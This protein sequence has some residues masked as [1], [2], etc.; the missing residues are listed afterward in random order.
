VNG[1]VLDPA[2]QVVLCRNR[3]D[4]AGEDDERMAVTTG[5][6]REQHVVAREQRFERQLVADVGHGLRLRAAHRRDAHKRECA[7]GQAVAVFLLGH[8]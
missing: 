1:P 8:G 2:R 7:L 6:R 5:C 4:V 3:V